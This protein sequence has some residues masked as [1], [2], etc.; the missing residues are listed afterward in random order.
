MQSVSSQPVRLVLQYVVLPIALS[1]ALVHVGMFGYWYWQVG[2]PLLAQLGTKTAEQI[3][4]AHDPYYTLHKVVRQQPQVIKGRQTRLVLV[5]PEAGSPSRLDGEAYYSL[6]P[7]LP[8]KVVVDSA[9]YR[10]V[11][12]ELQVGD[13]IISEQS[14]QLDERFKELEGEGYFVYLRQ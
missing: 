10:A 11:V 4:N 12:A 2:S 6:Y 13:I 14:L 1:V 8:A 5:G 7:D 3:F 9:E